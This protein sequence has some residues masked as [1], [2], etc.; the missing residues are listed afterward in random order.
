MSRN[1]WAA[2]IVA[3][4][5]GMSPLAVMVGSEMMEQSRAE[6]TAAEGIVNE[7]TLL[8]HPL[9]THA[10]VWLKIMI[11]ALDAQTVPAEARN[12]LRIKFK[13][14]QQA[15]LRLV[16][17]R[18]GD[19]PGSFNSLTNAELHQV[20]SA[21]LS[22]TV[23]EYMATARREG[24]SEKFLSDFTR[25]HQKIV[26]L[27]VNS[28]NDAAYSSL[29]CHEGCGNTRVF[30]VLSAYDSALASTLNDVE[31]TLVDKLAPAQPVGG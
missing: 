26:D 1:S 30:S 21:N 13:A 24:I 27:L 28:I 7:A 23:D 10:D 4:V 18:G 12:F 14:F 16:E 11:P 15:L 31:R 22:A 25:W 17:K 20:L 8:A 9:F 6:K 2:V 5:T 3:F 19:G 29:Y